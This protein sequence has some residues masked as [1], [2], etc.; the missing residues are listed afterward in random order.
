[1]SNELLL[2]LNIILIYGSVLVWY[3]LF[4]VKGL[5]CWNVLATIAA[6][7]E[8]MILI[9]AFGMEQ[10]LGNILFASTFLTTDILSE[11]AGKKE[12][13]TAVNLG[14]LTSASFIVVSQFWL[15]YNPSSNDTIFPHMKAV[16]S[17]TPRIMLTGLLVYAVVQR[18]DVWLYHRWWNLTKRYCG[19]SKRF[20][21]LRNNGS[22]LLSQLLNAILFTLGAFWG[23]YPTEAILEIIVISYLIFIVTSLTD[24]P[25]VYLARWM[26]TR[27]LKRQEKQPG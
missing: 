20:L 16:F 4:D 13:N 9:N 19:D 12:A 1:M 3:G 6:N 23:K 8:V 15:L 26:K 27:K 7:I 17:N 11:V 25:A 22:T 21:W 24:T 14:I 2:I 10:T 18:L 5:Y